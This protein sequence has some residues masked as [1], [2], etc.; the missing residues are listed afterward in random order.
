MS[1]KV[2]SLG[3]KR[4][5][6]LHYYVRDLE[7][8]RRFYTERLDFQEIAAS[9]PELTA[10]AAQ[11]SVVFQA[12]ECVIVCSQPAGEGG[13]AWRYLRKHPDGVGTVIFEVEDIDR[14]FRLLDGRGGTPIDE[15]H[16]VTEA[17][18]SF[19]S[20]S[21]TTPFGDTTFRFVERR[22]YPALFPGC[23]AYDAPRGGANRFGIARFDHITSNF[24]TM[25]PALLWMEHVLGLEPF[26]QIAF[27]TNDVAKDAD[28]GSGLR[29]AVMWDPASGVKFANNEPYR[30]HFKS[31]QINV[32]HEEHRGDGVQHVALAVDDILA[33]VRAMRA[34][35]V[36]FMPTPA[37]YY[38]ML[39]E[40]LQRL[41]IGQIDE[42]VAELR[43]LEVLVDGDGARSYL[44]QIFLKESSG[45]HRDPEAGPFFFELIQRKGDR[46]FGAGNFRALFE[47]IERQQKA[48]GHG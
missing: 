1:A 24:Q 46:G 38:D 20:F 32:F 34:R 48:G 9:S 21:I 31:S 16:R 26:W 12:G 43:D 11:R 27:H 35:G 28:H 4:V 18:G 39:P 37:A 22:G 5:E 13:R 10:A 44:L 30:P 17:G 14:A 40:R 8:S 2:E 6:A 41:G 42:D 3:I 19:A 33:A 25:A 15:I 23:V 7:R 36:E 45:T 47:S 29:S